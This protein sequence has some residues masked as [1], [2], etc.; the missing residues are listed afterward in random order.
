MQE[1]TIEKDGYI[2]DVLG[3]GNVAS[4]LGSCSD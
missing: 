1:K 2:L 4:A 3:C